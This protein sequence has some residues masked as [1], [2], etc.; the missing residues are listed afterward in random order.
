MSR[1]DDF[2]ER[3]YERTAR[4]LGADAVSLLHDRRVIVFGVGGVG[5]FAAAALVRAGCGAVGCQAVRVVVDVNDEQ[6]V[7]DLCHALRMTVGY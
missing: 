4:L 6:A 7:T 5:S 2:V 1:G 3:Q